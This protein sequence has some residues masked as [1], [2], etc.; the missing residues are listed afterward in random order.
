LQNNG[1]GCKNA[2]ERNAA[3]KRVAHPQ[4]KEQV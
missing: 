3:Q 4:N 1:T 2:V